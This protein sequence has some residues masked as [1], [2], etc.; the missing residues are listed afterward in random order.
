MADLGITLSQQSELNLFAGS[1]PR[2]EVP[3]VIV[4]GAGVMVKGTV[5]GMITATGQYD[6]YDNADQTGLTTARLILAEDIDATLQAVNTTGFASGEFNEDALTGLD[7]NAKLDF[8]GTP[9]FI[10]KI[11]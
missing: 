3:I 11:Y 2:V 1:F 8:M 6:A 10:K 9:I 7:D 5:L 4:N